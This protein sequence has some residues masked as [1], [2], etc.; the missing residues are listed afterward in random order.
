MQTEK[1]QSGEFTPNHYRY[2]IRSLR[3]SSE[4]YGPCEVCKKHVT[5][6][7]LQVE[8]RFYSIPAKGTY[9]GHSGWTHYECH[10]FFGHGACLASRRR[11]TFSHN[12]VDSESRQAYIVHVLCDAKETAETAANESPFPAHI[13]D[14]LYVHMHNVPPPGK[15]E[16]TTEYYFDSYKGWNYLRPGRYDELVAYVRRNPDLMRNYFYAEAVRI[17]RENDAVCGPLHT[18]K[19][20]ARDAGVPVD[21]L[22]TADDM[23]DAKLAE[24]FLGGETCADPIAAHQAVKQ[25]HTLGKDRY[26]TL[27]DRAAK[28]VTS[29]EFTTLEKLA[30][31]P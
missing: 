22:G 16:N 9:A 29:S 6:V 20:L 15:P 13:A 2:R 19:F 17:G 28:Y 10:S 4:R 31:L 3:H 24:R 11:G 21:A 26:P 7:F 12:H 30:R 23:V 14:I 1:H 8:E 18:W 25:V 5:E 27:W